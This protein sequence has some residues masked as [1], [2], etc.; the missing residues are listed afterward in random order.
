MNANKQDKPGPASVP[1]GSADEERQRTL[2]DAAMGKI[3]E[4]ERLSSFGRFVL[5][6]Q[7]L[8][9]RPQSSSSKI[10]KR[11][12]VKPLLVFAATL[13]LLALALLFVLSQ[14]VAKTSRRFPNSLTGPA[15]N[16]PLPKAFS[17]QSAPIAES[18]LAGEESSSE[19][20]PLRQTKTKRLATIH[21]SA[22]GHRLRQ[23][24]QTDISRTLSDDSLR[25]PA[26]VFVNDPAPAGASAGTKAARAFSGTASAADTVLPQ[27][28]EI[29]ARTT[30]AISSG[31]ES[32]VVAIVD[33]D[34]KLDSAIVIPQG[35][36]AIG[37]TA[38][39]ARNRVNVK[40]TAIVLPDDS[41]VKFSGLALM[42]DGSAGLAGKTAGTNHR[43]LAGIARTAAGAGALAA[44]FAGQTSSTLGQPFSEGDLL[45]NQVGAEIANEGYSA[46][47]RLAQPLGM[48]TVRV[49]AN[50]RIRIFLLTPI[51]FENGKLHVLNSSSG[52]SNPT[53]VTLSPS[54]DV[55]GVGQLESALETQSATIQ[56]LEVEIAHLQAQ[57][58]TDQGRKTH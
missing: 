29:L 11:W 43:V 18:Q 26:T 23:K 52:A 12:R 50:Q 17:L 35:S 16:Q 10:G 36:R 28:T 24:Q 8:F 42:G 19:S 57:A 33:Q 4:S 6:A 31:L 55:R 38:G 1:I 25:S 45:R 39:A 27:G 49:P 41:E 7:N 37:L 15:D 3:K 21:N 53:S 22:R 40:F 30:N 58:A 51:Q 56:A 14:P 13:L 20:A 32:P 46:S 48:P 44:E 2:A 5:K 47:N 9:A 54:A 34:V